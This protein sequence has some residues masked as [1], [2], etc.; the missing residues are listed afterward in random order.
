[1]DGDTSVGGGTASFLEGKLI[2]LTECLRDS[3][4]FRAQLYEQERQISDLEARLDKVVMGCEKMV[5][6]SVSYTD[7]ARFFTTSIK[8]LSEHFKE[9]LTIQR[10]MRQFCD[11]LP[12]LHS[13][14]SV[15][16]DQ[17]HVT[18]QKS[19]KA[20]LS[21]NLSKVKE[22]KKTFDRISDDLN[23]AINRSAHTPKTKPQ[24]A[25]EAS[26]ILANMETQFSHHAIDYGYQ[27]NTIHCEKGH[28]VVH[29]L[30]T[31]MRAQS[32]FFSQGYDLFKVYDPFI[33]ELTNTAEALK[34]ESC[35]EMD[36]M[37]KRHSLVVTQHLQ[38]GSP[39]EP[40]LPMDNPA[41]PIE[42]SGYLFKKGSSGFKSWSRRYFVLKENQLV[43]HSRSKASKPRPHTIATPTT[44]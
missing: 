38:D 42:I 10:S 27:V 24:E 2:D 26:V 16:C 40:L 14:Y 9:N 1:M 5:D 13:L 7:A 15:L 37:S 18:I 39:D 30:L 12:K 28:E 19:L 29:N 36:K 8:E 17:A 33:S 34:K 4:G 11:V 41:A 20:F 21:G 6:A 23:T 22:T 31:F 25:E 32:S 43:Y 3:P 35:V 44:Y